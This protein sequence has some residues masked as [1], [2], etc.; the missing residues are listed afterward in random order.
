M[1]SHDNSDSEDFEYVHDIS[2]IG[3]NGINRIT[4]KLQLHPTITDSVV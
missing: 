2:R 4:G 3:E 1:S